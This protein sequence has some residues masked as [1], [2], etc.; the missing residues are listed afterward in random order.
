MLYYFLISLVILDCVFYL[1]LATCK[2]VYKKNL[3]PRII[4]SSGED[5]FIPAGWSHL[6]P[7]AD[8][9]VEVVQS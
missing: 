4:F 3:R 1:K 5:L 9:P 8:D 6:N 2:I 7:V